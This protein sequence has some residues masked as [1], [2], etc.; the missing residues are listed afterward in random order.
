MRFI[1]FSPVHFEDWD[2]RNSV[3]R[4]IGGSETSH[5]EMAWRLARRGHE[6]ICYAPIPPDCPGEWRDTFWKRY[7][8]ADFTLDGLW[9]L[10][11]C[12]EILDQFG[13]CRPDQPRWLMCQDTWYPTMTPERAAKLDRVLT[14]CTDHAQHML[15]AAPYLKEKLWRTSNGV[16]VDLIRDLER[17]PIARNPYKLVYASSPDRGLVPL[18]EIF[19]HARE[20][21]PALELHIFYGLDNIEKLLAQGHGWATQHFAGLKAKLDRLTQQPGV[22]WR[23]RVS[24]VELYQEW[25][26]AGLWAYPTDFTETSCITCMEAQALGA[27]PITRPLWALTD[28]VRHGVWIDGSPAMDALV[29]ARYV[30]EIYRLT[31]DLSIQERLRGP[32]MDWARATHNWERLID[33]WE[34]DLLRLPIVPAQFAFQHKYAGGRILNIGCASDPT[35]FARRGAVNLD[36]ASTDPIGTPSA[37]HLFAD[38]RRPLP[39]ALGRFECVILGDILEHLRPRDRVRMLKQSAAV[40]TPTGYLLITCPFDHRPVAVQ[41]EG[42]EATQEYAPGVTAY[43]VHRL[44]RESLIRACLRAGLYVDHEEPIDYNFASGIGLIARVARTP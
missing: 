36:V 33:Q 26:S 20:L 24:Q 23:G 31:Q 25:L 1:F 11:R 42:A 21:Q 14:L 8:E 7:E 19:K 15:A 17:K 5:V 18:L 40:L 34:C 39:K 35:G 10:Y 4:G 44:T 38:A 43:H 12:P 6:V 16:K 3:D 29:R 22:T 41:C 27:I 32:M 2:W 13:P 30:G 37:A 28:N 9:I